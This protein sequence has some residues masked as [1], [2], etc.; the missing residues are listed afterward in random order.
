MTSTANT[1]PSRSIV[2]LVRAADRCFSRILAGAGP[3]SRSSIADNAFF[4]GHRATAG[5]NHTTALFSTEHCSAP[6]T[7]FDFACRHFT[8]TTVDFK[9]HSFPRHAQTYS[10]NDVSTETVGTPGTPEFRVFFTAR[11]GEAN[12]DTHPPKQGGT[13][14]KISPWHNLS[15]EYPH[16]AVPGSCPTGAGGPVFNFVCEIPHGTRRKFEMAKEAKHNPIWQDRKTTKEDNYGIMVLRHYAE[17]TGG[18]PGNYGFIPQ[19][20]EVAE[21]PDVITGIV[22][23]GDPID[24]VELPL[25]PADTTT[26]TERPLAVGAVTQV[27]IL[28]ALALIDGGETDWKLLVRRV[29][30]DTPS[31]VNEETDAALLNKNWKR[32]RDWFR[33]YKTFDGKGELSFFGSSRQSSE[34]DG[35]LF[36]AEDALKALQGAHDAW[37]SKWGE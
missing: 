5:E 2:R 21:K 35:E 17:A 18:A 36:L 8:S 30:S 12:M 19:T 37:A 7:R 32:M 33:T 25:A 28:G 27:R 11:I 4:S 9:Q 34:V 6:R 1:L 26:S 23:D 13:K 14:V 3:P 10:P 15:C 24:A 31:G 29:N 22:G 16:E 20:L